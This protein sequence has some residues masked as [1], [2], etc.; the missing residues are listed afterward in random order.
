MPSGRPTFGGSDDGG[1]VLDLERIGTCS[2]HVLEGSPKVVH[3]AGMIL[4][5]QALSRPLQAQGA[6]IKKLAGG[7]AHRA[8]VAREWGRGNFSQRV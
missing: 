5:L 4:P 8:D 7:L 3:R 1:E 6:K 2:A